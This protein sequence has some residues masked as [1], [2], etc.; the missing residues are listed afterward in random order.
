MKKKK[1][2]RIIK[3]FLPVTKTYPISE[4]S[5]EE[6]MMQIDLNKLKR[7]NR[8]VKTYKDLPLDLKK[9]I[10][11]FYVLDQTVRE[12]I[13]QENFTKTFFCEDIDKK[14]YSLFYHYIMD[15][16]SPIPSGL[17]SLVIVNNPIHRNDLFNMLTPHLFGKYFKSLDIR[18]NGNYGELFKNESLTKNLE[19]LTLLKNPGTRIETIPVNTNFK[20][21]KIL[22][23]ENFSEQIEPIF[24]RE[25]LKDINLIN[26][27][28][29]IIVN[30]KEEEE[31]EEIEFLNLKNLSIKNPPNARYVKKVFGFVSFPSLEKLELLDIP[32]FNYYFF[33]N[34]FPN[35]KQLLISNLPNLKPETLEKISGQL[36][37]FLLSN[38]VLITNKIF[39]LYNFA[40]LE[41]L[42]I[43]RGTQTLQEI[44]IEKDSI[45]KFKKLKI[46]FITTNRFFSDR[47]FEV[48]G[49][50][51]K[52]EHLYINNFIPI[53]V[54][55]QPHK[56]PLLKKLVGYN[57]G[58]KGYRHVNHFIG[59]HKLEKLEFLQFVNCHSFNT[60]NQC[61][62]ILG[63]NLVTLDLSN[64]GRVSWRF[65]DTLFIQTD[66]PKL[67]KLTLQQ[68]PHLTGNN[69]KMTG[70]KLSELIFI[71]LP[72]FF[73][74]FIKKAIYLT[75]FYCNSRNL[76]PTIIK[77]ENSDIIINIIEEGESK[78]LGISTPYTYLE[79]EEEEEGEEEEEEE[80]EEFF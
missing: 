16:G 15:A 79:E 67:R 18:H 7:F 56:F 48:S 17:H 4:M 26:S 72:N 35:I 77:V 33:K 14:V 52:L 27:N 13:T 71:D 38:N 19:N 70:E 59:F 40:S 21:L 64:L 8:V 55:D 41:A 46:L 31:E 23:L 37:Y 58:L 30:L 66:F 45:T 1:K 32:D 42:Y 75:T 10:L 62:S 24:N 28:M 12:D 69:W 68:L 61:C 53:I 76:H 3:F 78:I 22:S 29:R 43:N 2:K 51:P 60:S 6:Y 65:D 54:N 44:E 50:F 5:V 80:G 49:N 11:E 20:S 9:Q 73:P 74:Y 57:I 34:T 63:T 47:F 39:E 25:I 36:S